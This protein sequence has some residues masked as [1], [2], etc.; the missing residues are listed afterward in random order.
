MPV[1]RLLLEYDGASYFGWQAQP[2]LPTVQGALD[3]ALSIL[4]R[5]AIRTTGAGRTDR[6]VH[7]RGQVASFHSTARLDCRRIAAGIR[8]ICGPMIQV[9]VMEEA[10][11][12]FH[13]RHDARW[14]AYSY[15]LLERPSPLWRHHAHCPPALPGLAELRATS[16]P[17]LGRHDFTSFAN[18]SADSADPSCEVLHAAWESWDHGLLF[19]VRADHFLYKMVRTVVGTLLREALPGGGGS[20]A[21]RRIIGARDRRLASAPL[22]PMGLCLEAVGYEPPWP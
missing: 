6:G 5:E 21:M 14:R 1:Y 18:V 16:E 15:R 19:R 2:S 9:R 22:P 4:T 8:G 7:A 11:P 17:L 12:A 13:A 3:R 20:E 10:D